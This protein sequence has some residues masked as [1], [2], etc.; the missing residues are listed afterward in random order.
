MVG[1][2]HGL[3]H[4]C[5]NDCGYVQR[6]VVISIGCQCNGDDVEIVVLSGDED[7]V[8]LHGCI[9]SPAGYRQRSVGEGSVIMCLFNFIV[10]KH[11]SR[12]GN[13]CVVVV[14][15]FECLVSVYHSPL[16]SP[17]IYLNSVDVGKVTGKLDG[18]EWKVIL[19]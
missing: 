3:T 7:C 17:E 4:C 1:I 15:Q 10:W 19:W 5:S 13:G 18:E 6:S 16:L 11:R 8:H 14:E 12:L 2:V 9:T